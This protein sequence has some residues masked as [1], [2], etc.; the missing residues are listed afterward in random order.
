[1]NEI[2]GLQELLTD[3]ARSVVDTYKGKIEDVMA[4]G[5]LYNSITYQVDGKG[6]N[7]DVTITL[8]E[9][10]KNIEYGRSPGAKFP[11][12]DAIKNWISV[13]GITP[14]PYTLPTGG[15]RIPTENQLAF[16]IGRKIARDGIQAKPYL[17]ESVDENFQKFSGALISLLGQTVFNL[18]D[19]T[20]KY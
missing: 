4:S 14:Q 17:Q 20:F 13:K 9:Y 8:E 11:P 3:Y 16:L 12:V 1:M 10:W 7:F 15:V 2:P 5:Q 19:N 18:I 6:Q